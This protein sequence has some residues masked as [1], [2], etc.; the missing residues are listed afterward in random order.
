MQHQSSAPGANGSRTDDQEQRPCFC[1]EGWVF[2]GSIGYD[3]EEIIESVRCRR[4]GGTGALRGG[5][6]TGARR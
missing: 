2:I 5:E 1:L 3:G 4:C 6:A